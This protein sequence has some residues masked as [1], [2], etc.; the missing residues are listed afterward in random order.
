MGEAAAAKNRFLRPGQ[1]VYK[2]QYLFDAGTPAPPYAGGT[3]T[4]AAGPDREKF[5]ALGYRER[6]ALKQK[7]DVY[8]RQTPY[9][10]ER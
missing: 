10:A 4:G 7:E 8:K 3:G 2:R 6:L 1:D 5:R 9:K